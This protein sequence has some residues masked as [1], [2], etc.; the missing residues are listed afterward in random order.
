MYK[1]IELEINPDLSGDTGVFEV[2]WVEYPAIE[3]D[4]V[5]F[6][7]QKFYKAPEYVQTKA[8]QAIKENEKRGNPAGTQVGKVRAQQLC[9]GEEISL[10]TVKRIKSFL[11][12]AKV[13]DTGNWDDNGTIAMGLWGGVEA[14]S[15]VD[16]ILSQV[17]NQESSKQE[18][19]YPNAGES[20]DDFISRCVSY[21]VNEGRTTDE[22]VGKC[23]GMW[24]NRTFEVG[25]YA[26]IGPRGGIRE[27]DKAPKSKTKN[28]SPKGEGSAKGDASTTR[29]AVVT[30][31]VEE[32]L[33]KKADDFNEKYKD[34][35]GYGAN[36]GSLKTVYQRGVGAYN[37]SHSPAVR[38]SQQ[39]GLART[40]AF[41]YL[42][43][44]GRPE[45][46]AYIQD[47]DL[48]P[49]G[50]P[51]KDKMTQQ[52]AGDKVSFDWDDTLD[53]RYGRDLLE[54]EMSRGNI[55]Y[56]ISA[57]NLTTKE[58]IDTSIKYGFPAKNIYTVG[59]NPEKIEKIKELGIKRHYDNNFRVVQELGPV[60]IKFDYDVTAL[61]DYVDYADTGLTESVLGFCGCG[62][63]ESD[64]SQEMNVFGYT[65]EYFYICPGARALFENLITMD[66]DD[67]TKGMIRSAAQIAD[68]VFKIEAEVIRKDNASQ[69]ELDEAII[70]VDDFKDLILEIDEITGMNQETSFMDGH[71][72]TIKKYLGKFEQDFSTWDPEDQELKLLFDQVK[73]AHPYEFEYITQPNLRG[74]TLDE[75]KRINHKNPTKY[76]KYERILTGEPHRAFCNSLVGRYFRRSQIYALENY[77]K[78][79]GHQKQGYSKWLYKGGPNCIHAWVEYSAIGDRIQETNANLGIAGIPPK[80][81]PNNGY[82]SEETKRK[83]EI[84]YIISQQNLSSITHL[85]PDEF[86]CTFNGICNVDFSKQKSEIFASDKERRMVYTPLMIPNMLI[87]RYDEASE[88]KY[89]VKFR[90]ETI[91]QIRDKFMTELRNRKT[92][93]EH[94]DKKFDDAVLVESWIIESEKDK[95]YDLGFT[96]DQLP[97]GT[98][99]GVYKILET[100]QGDELWNKYI[101]PG[102]VQGMS[103]EGNFMLNFSE[104]KRDEY[105]LESIINILN[106]VS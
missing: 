61:P 84:A 48:L 30:K 88:E 6:S 69:Q 85:T 102:K 78:E 99:M 32:I 94:T 98:W 18:F 34:K 20:E 44:N 77:N 64:P 7:Q 50:H 36:V 60:G 62:F 86:D 74:F 104:I 75:I 14:L 35:L 24:N 37:T 91:V 65:T 2:A 3:Q 38:S 25:E 46:K 16:K 41:L 72:I 63:E 27:S 5:Y 90:P 95:A 80:N 66:V 22:A 82:Y 101:K 4:L 68:N 13:Y 26:E 57:R 47:D 19:V 45:R 70:L 55:I 54:Q 43:K 39:W 76:Y 92:N 56:I 105:L 81:L 17:E 33:Q 93:L 21:V 97:I 58:M 79:F 83:S 59:S 53:T 28:P 67:D 100:P 1:I 11:E 15:W 8:C 96:Q 71:I 42:L 89:F 52:Y 23:Y 103:V 29:G 87:P 9:K 40:N 49:S 31:E 51:K 106:E 10:E 12:R 73:E